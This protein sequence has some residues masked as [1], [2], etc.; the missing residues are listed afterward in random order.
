MNMCLFPV[1]W[2]SALVPGCDSVPK[3]VPQ[4]KTG[5][6]ICCIYAFM[7]KVNG[8]RNFISLMKCDKISHSYRFLALDSSS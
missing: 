1:M 8:F 4:G 6:L 5:P 2:E 7:A 3:I